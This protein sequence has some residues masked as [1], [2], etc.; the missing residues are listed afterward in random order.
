MTWARRGGE[1]GFTLAELLVTIAVLGL[2]MGAVFTVQIAG[3]S[4]FTAGS[5]L[6]ESQQ[7]ARTAMLIDED[8]RLVGYGYVLSTPAITAATATS[9]TFWADLLNASTFLTADLPAGGNT[10]TV[11]SSAGVS[12]GDTIYVVNGRTEA[13]LVVQAIPDATTVR[14]AAGA[15]PAFPRGSMVGRAR[16]ITYAWASSALTR[17]AGDGAGAQTLATGVQSLQLSYFDVSDVQITAA[18]L[19]AN[20]ASIRRVAVAVTAQSTSPG[21]VRSF[22]ISSNIRPRNL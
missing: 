5:D 6:A 19:A 13:T 1:A 8:L 15:G 10:L 18:N 20:L 12:I 11:N 21:H 9:I 4:A 3:N 16:R 17:D 7:S 2:I 14:T 22:N